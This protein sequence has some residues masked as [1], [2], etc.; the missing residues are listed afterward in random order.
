M[1]A[2]KAHPKRW[3]LRR[4]WHL[5]LR[6]KGTATVGNRRDLTFCGGR[7]YAEEKNQKPQREFS[8][9]LRFSQLC[10]STSARLSDRSGC[11]TEFGELC[12]VAYLRDEPWLRPGG[13]RLFWDRMADWHRPEDD[14]MARFRDG[15]VIL[16]PA[17]G[18]E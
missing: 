4:K 3:I 17:L 7:S 15:D 12:R 1:W 14:R 13:R 5:R 8:L 2:G 10:F 9:R 6:Q 16:T 11:P 18:E